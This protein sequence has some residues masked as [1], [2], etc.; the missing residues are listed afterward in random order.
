MREGRIDEYWVRIEEYD[1]KLFVF[2]SKDG[3]GYWM[4]KADPKEVVG[5]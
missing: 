4:F 5:V 1:D 2:I 3:G